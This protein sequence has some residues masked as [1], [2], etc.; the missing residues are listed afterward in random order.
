[1]LKLG[2]FRGFV[3]CLTNRDSEAA[4]NSIFIY[5]I[6]FLLFFYTFSL[7]TSLL[8]TKLEYCFSV[9]S[10]PTLRSRSVLYTP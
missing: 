6:L 5:F 10:V 8:S 4:T 3:P 1:M 2:A 7:V 9:V